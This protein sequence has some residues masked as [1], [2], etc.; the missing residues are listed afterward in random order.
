MAKPKKP[1]NSP[2]V[3][4][5]K[6]LFA[7]SGN[8]CAFPGCSQAAYNSDA[9]SILVEI[10]HIEGDRPTSPRYRAS[11]PDEERHGFENLMLL[12]GTHHTLVDDNESEFTVERLKEMK[13]KQEA[14]GAAGSPPS[15]EDQDIATTYLLTSYVTTVNIET[16]V[17]SDG[18]SGGQ[19][20]ATIIN[21][22]NP[23]RPQR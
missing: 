5:I 20:A 19:T 2:R 16:A 13:A 3:S 17:F 4:T 18:Q 8:R 7:V 6:R 14:A 21:V 10:A 1:P 11:Q 22:G 23:E 12:C 9:D 15:A